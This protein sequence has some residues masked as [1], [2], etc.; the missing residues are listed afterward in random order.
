ME[1][2]CGGFLVLV[3]LCFVVLAIFSE[4]SFACLKGT[5][6]NACVHLFSSFVISLHLVIF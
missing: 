6:T 2:K 3:V 4:K 1:R 5:P